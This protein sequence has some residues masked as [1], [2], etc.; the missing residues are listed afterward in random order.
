[1]GPAT[2]TVCWFRALV[3]ADLWCTITEKECLGM[4]WSLL[5]LRQYQEFLKFK[6]GSHSLLKWLSRNLNAA[7]QLVGRKR[8]L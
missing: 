8:Q 5:L 1:M 7:G 3:K 4:V 6:L 2:P